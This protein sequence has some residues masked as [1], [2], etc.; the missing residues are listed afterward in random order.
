MGLRLNGSTSG[1]SEIEAPAVAGD[2]TF[3]LPGTGGTLDRLNRAGN[4]IQIVNTQTGTSASGTTTLPIDNTIPQNTEGTEFMTLAITP[5]SASSKL[6]IDV[7]YCGGIS[8][9]DNLAVALFQDSIA[10]ALAVLPVAPPANA[11]VTVPLRHYMTAD[12]TSSTT[13]KVRAGM[14]AAGTTFFNGAYFGGTIASSI[15]ITEIAA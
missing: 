3:T 9:A 8:S 2:Q 11:F 5:T 7:I 4:I 12:T 1:Y 14:D 6:I 13:F 10:N 15:T